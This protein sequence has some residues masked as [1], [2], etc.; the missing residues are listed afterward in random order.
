M[1]PGLRRDLRFL[2]GRSCTRAQRP[3]ARTPLHHAS[4]GPPPPQR[5]EGAISVRG[6]GEAGEH[7]VADVLDIFG[8]DAGLDRREAGVLEIALDK[9]GVAPVV[10]GAPD[11]DRLGPE[12][13]VRKAD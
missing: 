3:G 9:S 4:H 1:G 7:R 8:E 5:W 6:A 13:A 2:L 11:R 10:E 12:V